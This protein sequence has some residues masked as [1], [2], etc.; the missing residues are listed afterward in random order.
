M[1]LLKGEKCK[2]IIVQS[3]LDS[4]NDT[5]CYQY[6]T[7][8]YMVNTLDSYIVLFEE[9]TQ[10]D[11]GKNLYQDL[12]NKEKVGRNILI[13]YTNFNEEYLFN[14]KVWLNKIEH[15]LGYIVVLA[16]K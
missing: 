4:K 15:D 10:T 14:L 2:S 6:V 3:I 7:R 13:V 9:M 8:K 12:L 11:F 16:C 1:L 5:V